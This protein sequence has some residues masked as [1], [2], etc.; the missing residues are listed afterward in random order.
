MIVL[1]ILPHGYEN[2]VMNLN[3]YTVYSYTLHGDYA[4]TI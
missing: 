3:F 1:K 2:I 4:V